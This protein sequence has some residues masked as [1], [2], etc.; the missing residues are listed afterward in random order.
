MSFTLLISAYYFERV[1]SS[2]IIQHHLLISF[3]FFL[4]IKKHIAIRVFM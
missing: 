4:L 1:V 2:F 3:G